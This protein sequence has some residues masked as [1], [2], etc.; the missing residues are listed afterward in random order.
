MSILWDIKKAVENISVA[1]LVIFALAV[2]CV[3]TT[4][5]I[6][7]N[8]DE[9]AQKTRQ[10]FNADSDI[11]AIEQDLVTAKAKLKLIPLTDLARAELELRI[12]TDTA[13]LVL[14]Q[15]KKGRLVKSRDSDQK[16]DDALFGELTKTANELT[17]LGYGGL[18]T[19]LMLLVKG[20]LKHRA[21]KS[22]ITSI[23]PYIDKLKDDDK[24]AIR[25]AQTPG[26]S[27]LVDGMQGKTKIPIL[28]I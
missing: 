15:N 7:C 6:G 13:R 10:I 8:I 28:P 3:I 23:Q 1:L 26:A 20:F 4:N 25:D 11:D 19:S 18:V 12:E 9:I 17:P 14:L 16:E 22:V 27:K 24:Q 21:F 2:L 5:I